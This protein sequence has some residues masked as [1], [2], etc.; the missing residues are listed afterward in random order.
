M[1][2]RARADRQAAR[3]RGRGYLHA[4]RG[5]GAAALGAAVVCT[6]RRYFERTSFT[7]R[8]PRLLPV[9]SAFAVSIAGLAIVYQSLHQA[10]V[11]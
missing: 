7:P 6:A 8:I 4:G 3:R 1:A 5:D 9:A 10:G 2:A 11:M